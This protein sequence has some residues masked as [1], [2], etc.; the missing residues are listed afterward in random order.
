MTDYRI[1]CVTINLDQVNIEEALEL[2]DRCKDYIKKDGHAWLSPNGE[3][4]NEKVS[5]YQ[6]Y[7][8][9]LRRERSF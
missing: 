4:V 8:D 7:D 1:G 6:T 2:I 9:V 5:I 3:F